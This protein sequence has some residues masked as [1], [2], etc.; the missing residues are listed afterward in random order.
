MIIGL[1][2]SAVPM[3]SPN[4]PRIRTHRKHSPG[5]PLLQNQQNAH[6]S[7]LGFQ[8]S[9]PEGSSSRTVSGGEEAQQV[10]TRWVQE[11]KERKE[12]PVPGS[13]G[14]LI[15]CLPVHCQPDGPPR[16]QRIYTH[17]CIIKYGG[18]SPSPS[19]HLGHK[20]MPNRTRFP[21]I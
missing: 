9:S 18:H 7:V 20:K 14:S 4:M 16:L 5:K 8:Q 13:Q 12:D 17:M 6:P 2:R 11:G 15:R 1:T 21:S 10:G 19:P 3:T